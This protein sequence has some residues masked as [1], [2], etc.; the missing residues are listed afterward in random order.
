MDVEDVKNEKVREYFRSI[1]AE[2]VRLHELA[3]KAKKKGFDPETNVDIPLAAN[4]SQR[5]E[6]LIGVIFPQIVG[7]GVAQRIDELEKKYPN[8]DLRIALLLAEGIAKQEFCKFDKQIDAINAGARAGFAYITQGV[9]SAP[10]EGLID[11]KFKKRRDGKDYLAMCYAGPIRAGGSSASA[12]TVVIGDYLRKKLGIEP[13]DPSDEEIS[14]FYVEV[15]DY[16]ERVV[17]TQYT[18]TEEEIRFIITRLAVELDGD[19]TERLEVMNFKNIERMDTNFIRGGMCLVM[20]EGLPLKVHKVWKQLGKWYKEFGLENWDW[21]PEFVELKKKLH[22]KSKKSD[23]EEVD[24][25]KLR[26]DYTYLSEIVAGRPV[27]GYPMQNGGFRLRYGRTRLTG[28][29]SWAISPLT[30]RV[31]NDYLATGSQLRVERPGKS[32]ALTVCD[33]IDGPVLKLKDGSIVIP[34]TEEETKKIVNK[35]SEILYIGDILISYG[36]FYEQGHELVPAGYCPEWWSKQLEAA[37]KEPTERQQDLIKKPFTFRPTFEEAKQLSKE[38]NVPLHPDYIFFWKDI[39]LEQVRALRDFFINNKTIEFTPPPEVKRTLELI[40]FPHKV[41]D[42]KVIA[43]QDQLDYL[44]ENLGISNE[45]K[46]NKITTALDYI[47]SFSSHLIRDKFGTAIGNRMGRP[48]KA[49]IR[50]LK[51]TPTVMFPVSEQGGRL[52]SVNAAVDE[53]TVKSSFPDYFCN[54]CDKITI[55]PRCEVCNELTKLQRH[56]VVCKKKT[57]DLKC[58]DKRTLAYTR[59]TIDVRY[60]FNE[61]KKRL[62]VQNTPSLIKG[63][64]GTSNKDHIVEYLPKGLLRAKYQL[65][66]NKDCTIRYDL[67]EL[68][69]TQF[70]PNE[71]GLS[72]EKAKELG[73]TEDYLGKPLTDGDQVLEIFPQDVILPSC[74][75]SADEK[76]DDVFIKVANFVDE[77]LVK[78]YGMDPVYNIKTREDLIGQIIIGLAP[79]TSAGIVGR[80]IGFSEVVCVLAHPYWHAAQRRDLDGEETCVI[81]GM[82]AF[83]N[84]SRQYLPNRRGGS[85]DA[86]LVLNTL[87]NPSEVDDEIFDLE[88]VYEYPLEMYEGSLELKKPWEIKGIGQ[89][90]E[91]VGKPNQYDGVGFTHPVSNMNLGVRVS[92]YKS[93]PTMVEKLEGQMDLA[94]K[95]RAVQVEDVAQLVIDKHF[96]RDI[97]GNLRKY[98]MQSFRCTNCNE[99][100]RRPPLSGKCVNC[101]LP[102]LV[103]TIAEGTVKKYVKP[104]FKLLENPNMPPYLL[105]SLA[106][107]KKRINTVFEEEKTKQIGLQSFFT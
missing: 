89:I 46:Q 101:G 9:V 60:Y 18:P 84:F 90:K 80:I 82:D 48:E 28:Y 78:I 103:F 35:I 67:T 31:L 79:H 37:A 104:T 75:E 93:I 92:A 65:K 76:A 102:K 58:H 20:S 55:Y 8:G 10:L 4:V 41:V 38:L 83:L 53:G 47:N 97:K 26:P 98:T 94:Q 73:Y 43:E 15:R 5:V 3:G 13:Y 34:K 25:K 74:P 6:A 27:F 17:R 16:C 61:A 107:L 72:L 2:T 45:Q 30:M 1:K 96:I 51:G 54:K 95:I 86:P 87:L 52:R 29:G 44:L 14:R 99:I 69:A 88:T 40:A 24:D 39:T 63:V 7:S 49:K 62:G 64:R 91:R 81:L 36:D 22:D 106:L 71:I 23:K 42:G 12:M 56:C 66:M 33:S 19:P 85:M 11:V 32:T 105:Q 70:K 50:E 68:G 100:H 59:K 57:E 77:E 21:V